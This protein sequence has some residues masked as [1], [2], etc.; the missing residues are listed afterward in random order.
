MKNIIKSS[1]AVVLGFVLFTGCIKVIDP[2][3]T[4]STVTI[5]QASEAMGAY[6]NFVDA[7]TNSLCGSFIVSAMSAYDFGYPAF[8][9]VRDVMG[10]DIALEDGMESF[11]TWY[12]CTEAL[13]PS[14]GTCAMPWTYY[15]FWIKTCNTVLE[16]AGEEP[17]ED[18]ITG[19]GIAHAMRAMFY[20]DMAR[21]YA[22]QTYAK[23]KTAP[24]VPIVT[25]T[26]TL[27]DLQYNPS[28]TNEE[29]WSF[30]LSD[31]DKAEK[32]LA[33]YKRSDKYTP[34][35]SVV[36]GLKARAYLTMEDWANAESY[37]KKAQEGYSIT[38]EEQ[39]LSRTDGFNTPIDSWIFGVTYR[40]DDANILLNDGDSSWGAQMVV[41][42]SESGCG[43]AANYGTPK[44]I[45]Y[46]LY[47]T[48][49]DTDFRK[50]CYVDFA[51]DDLVV[52]NS[53][54]NGI[55]VEA[56]AEAVEALKAYSDV[57]EGLLTTADATRSKVVGGLEL[58]FRPNG[59]EHA[60]QYIGFTVAVPLMRV[61]EMMLIEAEAAGMQNE[62]NGI[63]LLTAFAQKRDPDYVYGTHS[64][65]T[66]ESSYATAFQNEVWWQRR[67]ELWGE[68]FATFDIKRL[69]KGVIR[70]YE[71]DNHVTPYRWNPG[72]YPTNPGNIY[73]QCMDLCIPETETNYN[74][75][76]V[77]H[78]PAPVKPTTD[79]P[80]EY[81]W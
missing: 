79:D 65:E 74:F 31:L 4:N 63:Q 39:Y 80:N 67:V 8:F 30:I 26:S 11:N 3:G 57:P 66:Y 51:I 53:S 68:G 33:D 43:Y 42:V 48:I 49:P 35:L 1:L 18:R 44:R 37:A 71:N 10:Q 40:S 21:M 7:V 54:G 62:G 50:K 32:Y 41:E 12:N 29:I 61:E 22:Q 17:E 60:N 16:M 47:Q 69:D 14:G 25:E 81:V 56:S 36:Y 78:N 55:D 20:M 72:F 73:P 58:K 15:Y 9:L 76:C 27:S 38:T 77:N 75:S 5:D 2:M 24:T 6:D 23:D 52:M 70:R 45:D 34:D 28:A 46:H 59:G 19:A 64:S 13:S